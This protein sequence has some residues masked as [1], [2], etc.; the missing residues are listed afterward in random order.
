MA[1]FVNELIPNTPATFSGVLRVSS[2]TPIIGIG[3]RLTT[4]GGGDVLMSTIPAV[5]E[6]QNG[7][8]Q[9]L[10]FPH[11]VS[12][13]GFTTELILLNRQPSATSS[14]Q[15]IFTGQDGSPLSVQ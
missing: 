3:L 4:N 12:G 9:P 2:V 8:P 13:G 1:R 6:T 10:L 14:G 7:T 5:S 15:V 11:V